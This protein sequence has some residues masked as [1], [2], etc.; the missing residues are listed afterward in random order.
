MDAFV[1]YCWAIGVVKYNKIYKIHERLLEQKREIEESIK[2]MEESDTVTQIDAGAIT[3]LKNIKNFDGEV[4][5][6]VCMALLLMF[7]VKVNTSNVASQFGL[8]S[9]ANL[10]SRIKGFDQQ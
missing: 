2:L 4:T 10:L 9:D 7:G 5:Q 3:D 1:L 8:I 6:Q